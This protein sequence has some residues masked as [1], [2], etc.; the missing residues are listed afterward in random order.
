MILRETVLDYKEK[1]F[2]IN[3]YFDVEKL[4]VKIPIIV[5]GKAIDNEVN[6]EVR[7]EKFDLGRY[8]YLTAYPE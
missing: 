4:V 1:V 7:V 5:D 3:L 6:S 2:C 8:N